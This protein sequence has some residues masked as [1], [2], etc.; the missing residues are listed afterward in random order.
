MQTKNPVNLKE[1]C[2]LLDNRVS[3]KLAIFFPVVGLLFVGASVGLLIEGFPLIEFIGLLSFGMV[4]FVIGVLLLRHQISDPKIKLNLELKMGEGSDPTRLQ[5]TVDPKVLERCDWCGGILGKDVRRLQKIDGTLIGTFCSDI[6]MDAINSRDL[7]GPG[8]I[9]MSVLLSIVSFIEGYFMGVIFIGVIFLPLGLCYLRQSL[10]GRSVASVV[11]K[12][13]R[14]NETTTD[15]LL[16]H[17][18]TNLV[19]CPLCDS[20][21]DLVQEG[22]DIFQIDKFREFEIEEQKIGYFREDAIEYSEFYE[23]NSEE[24]IE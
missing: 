4:L 1:V 19:S 12:N 18:V 10:K 5:V 17:A 15:T 3:C 8:I 9:I 13:S 20:S 6:C 22:D 16:V 14:R 24:S 21:L 7:L 23:L 2:H 11:P